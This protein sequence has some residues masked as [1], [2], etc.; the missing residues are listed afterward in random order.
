MATPAEK[1]FSEALG[2]N[3][4][5]WSTVGTFRQT[6][7]AGLAA[8]AE[9]KAGEAANLYE[10]LTKDPEYTVLLTNVEDFSR[11]MTKAQFVEFSAKQSVETAIN[12]LNAATILFAHSMVDGAAFDYCR[13]TALHAPQDWEP[14][15]LNKQ[16]PLSLVR[17]TSFE[18]IRRS[19]LEAILADLEM[20]S[21]EKKIDRLHARCKPEKGW[22]SMRGYAFDM[23][24]IKRLDKLRQDIVHGDALGRPIADVEN[25]F[26]YMQRTCMYFMGL[27]H[28]RYGLQID[29]VQAFVPGK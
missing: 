23:E 6:L 10:L 19:K 27:V 29:A 1:L 22:S 21:L 5:T 3:I 20:E 13:V 2:R 14:D 11:A 7:Q 8:A 26:D 12:S 9:A 28:Y 18:D 17:D 16:V 24:R 15:L 25:E 4:K